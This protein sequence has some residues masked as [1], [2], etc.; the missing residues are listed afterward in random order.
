[1]HSQ[2]ERMN[3]L[4]PVNRYSLWHYAALVLMLIVL[5]VQALPSFFGDHPVVSVSHHSHQ[6]LQNWLKAH[7]EAVSEVRYDSQGTVTLITPDISQQQNV[8]QQLKGTLGPDAEITL[9]YLSAAPTWL[10]RLG[11]EPVKLGLDLR[12]GVQLLLWVDTDQALAHQAEALVQGLNLWL[13]SQHL[14]ASATVNTKDNTTVQ[15]PMLSASDRSK[16]S[17]WFTEHYPQW[18]F[19]SA[20]NGWQMTDTEQ[21]A[22]S[23]QAV[24]Q[25]IDILRKRIDALGVAEASVQRQGKDY[26]RIELPGVHDPKQAK[27]VIGATASLAFYALDATS[28]K[29]LY[30]A[31]HNV[32]PLARHAI[33]GGEHI[34]DARTSVDEMR[35]PQV[36]IRLDGPG[37]ETMLAFTRRHLGDPMATVY[38]E[39]QA[40]EQGDLVANERVI[41]VAT[42]QSALSDRFRIT[43][44]SSPEEARNLSMLLRA[45]ALTAPIKIVEERAIGPTLGADNIKAGFSALAVGMIGMAIF[46]MLWYRRFGW[47]A[48]V[49]LVANLMMQVGLL[50]LLPGA[51]L[52]LPGI[53]GLV[54]TVG[55]AVD[56]NV[57]IFER[58]RDRLRAG[59]SLANAIDTGYRAAFST[60]FDA[61]ITTLISAVCLY[62]VGSGPLQG[63]AT[64]LILGLCA[65]MISGIVGTR[66]IINPIWGRDRRRAV[67]I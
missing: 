19:N 51:V 55:M 56:T 43:G 66:A 64:T 2:G 1:M 38:R 65:S 44:L 28:P 48:I 39:Y 36:D 47:V 10:S 30:D 17:A 57:L 5:T 33:L 6:G 61:N 13:D 32:V 31:Q 4:S 9:D 23:H 35:R 15:L 42:I 60:I 18:R 14:P 12:G 58:I 59:A 3:K 34:I 54:L 22:M 24:R 25:N 53:A 8:Q 40:N 27:N 20:A 29:R 46:M 67:T 49:S 37:G 52:T 11:A 63:F 41:N 26:I 7:P 50:A 45:G 62:A 21:D 16:A